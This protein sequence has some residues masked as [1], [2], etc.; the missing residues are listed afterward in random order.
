MISVIVATH[1]RR[2]LLQRTLAAL[3]RQAWP[4]TDVEVL[5]VDNDSTDG[6]SEWVERR[7]ARSAGPRIILLHETRPGKS[8]AVNLGVAHARGDV[9]AFTDDDVVPEPGWLQ[10]LARALDQSGADFVVGRILPDWEAPP[11][12]W[13]SPS[14]YG[15]LS[16]PDNGLSR[17]PIAAGQ[18]DHVMP[19]GA[20]MALRRSVVDRIGG[21][22]ADLGKLRDTLRSGEDHEFYVRMLRAGLRG[23]YEP[24]ARVTHLVPA[25]R[26]TREYFRD[27]M[28]QNGQTVAAVDRF[29]PP[30]VPRLLRAPRY[31]W[32]DALRDA[33]RFVSAVVAL[34]ACGRF[35]AAAR[36]RWFAGYLR[37]CWSRAPIAAQAETSA[38]RARAARAWQE[39]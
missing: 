24:E 6:T 33:A 29:H 26:L 32:R 7:R 22:H 35:A 1:N 37:G 14:L 8:H 36:L 17:L 34:D 31:L 5:V 16:V 38:E 11:P 3:G 18:N 39:Q 4:G 27:W 23:L 21:W 20:N 9:L 25:E 12:G 19:I 30:A 15:V 2:R 10:A 13:L 28:F